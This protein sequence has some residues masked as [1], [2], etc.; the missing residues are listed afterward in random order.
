MDTHKAI[1]LGRKNRRIYRVDSKES[2]YHKGFD[3]KPSITEST[4]YIED[5]PIFTCDFI[6]PPLLRGDTVYLNEIDVSASVRTVYR[7]TT[8]EYVYCLNH[9]EDPIEDFKTRKS[10]EKAS[11]ELKDIMMDYDKYMKKKARLNWWKFFRKDTTE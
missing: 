9:E 5:K 3:G 7:T 10:L 6:N 2:F 8:G 4:E 11:G 1:F